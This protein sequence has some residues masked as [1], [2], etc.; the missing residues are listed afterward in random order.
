M[1]SPISE[2]IVTPVAFADPPLLNAAGVHEPYAL[3]SII[4]V[5]CADGSYGLGESYGNTAHLE[6]L[7]AVAAQLPGLDPMRRNDLARVV[8]RHVRTVADDGGSAG[9]VSATR[10]FGA[11]ISPFEV[12]CLDVTGKALGRPVSDLLGGAVRDRVDFSA[13]LF[14]RFAAHPGQDVDEWGA[15]LDP[16]G[17]VAQARKMITE[18]G[19]GSIKLKAGVLAPDA[20]A[21]AILALREAFPDLPLR[22]D[23]NAVWDVDT[24]VRIAKRLDGVLEYFED[25]VRGI[26][27]M[28]ALSA[29]IDVPLAT[30]MCVVAWEHV[31]PAVRDDAVQIVLSDHHYWGGLRA[32]TE[33][34]RTCET[35]GLGLSMHSNSHLGIS[36]AAMV[37]LGAATPHLTYALDTH[38]PWKHEDLVTGAPVFSGGSAAVPTTPGLG[39]ELDRDALARLHEQ[40]LS[41]GI[42]ARDDIGYL[43]RNWAEPELTKLLGEG[44][45]FS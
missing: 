34:A 9:S 5:R 36:L 35:F 32:C 20:E 26:P 39:V 28:A 6:G 43:R 17:I 15:A 24:A 13:Y 29:Q 25:P 19:F 3:R 41:S 45:M 2:V 33:L 23:P 27:E 8:E 18:Y 16:E 10:T 44:H 12:A 22:I 14:Y 38:W 21:D 11:L 7:Q 37:H 4:E 30:N 1:T 31:A 42:R 40:Y